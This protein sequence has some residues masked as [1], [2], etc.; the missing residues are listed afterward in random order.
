MEYKKD[1]FID[2]DVIFQLS[3]LSGKP[4]MYFRAD[5]PTKYPDKAQEV[6]EFYVGKCDLNILNC[7]RQ[8]GHAYCYFDSLSQATE[9]FEEWF[10][11]KNQLGDDEEHFYIYQHLV[12]PQESINVTNE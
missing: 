5:G 8:F 9:S 3:N 10:P 4:V 11:N 12:F 6:W 1:Y 2:E 7:I